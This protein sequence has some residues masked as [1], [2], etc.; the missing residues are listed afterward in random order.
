MDYSS[1]YLEQTHA[2]GELIP[3]RRSIHPSRPAR[4]GAWVNYSPARGPLGGADCPRSAQAISSIHAA[5]RAVN[6]ASCGDAISWRCTAGLDC[7]VDAVEQTGVETPVDLPRTAPGGL[8]GFGGYTRS[9]CTRA[10]VAITVRA[11]SHTGTER[12]SR[13][14]Q[15][16]RRIAVRPAAAARHYRS[17]TTPY[18]CT[19]PI[20]GF[21]ETGDGRFVATS[22]SPSRG[23][24]RVPWR[25]GGHRGCCWRWCADSRL[26]T[27]HRAVRGC[28]GMAKMAGSPPLPPHGNFQTMTTSEIATVLA[29]LTPSMPPTLRPSWRCLLTTSTSVT[30]TGL[31]RA[32]MRCAGGAQA[33]SP[34]PQNL[35]AC[36]CTAGRGRRTKDGESGHRQDRRGAVV[37]DHVASVFR[38]EDSAS[39]LAATELTEDDLVD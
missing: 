8:V 38:H 10:D 20:R 30:R 17:A 18:I 7:A 26:P 16:I 11:N 6:T 13:R 12:G 32:T 4:A 31:Y 14:D 3:Q 39:A 25:R 22:A 5:S 34:Q 19:P 27:R 1:A 28:R 29:W 37:Q 9:Q 24:E 35:A 36:T 21:L 2:F 23:T 15:R 33:R